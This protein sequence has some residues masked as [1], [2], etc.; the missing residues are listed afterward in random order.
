MSAEAA[1]MLV[2]ITMMWIIRSLTSRAV[3]FNLEIEA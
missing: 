2:F 3:G 1:R